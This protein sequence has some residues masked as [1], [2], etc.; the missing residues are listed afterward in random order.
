VLAVNRTERWWAAGQCV[1]ING[2]LAAAEAIFSAFTVVIT[3]CITICRWSDLAF[4]TACAVPDVAM[5][6]GWRHPLPPPRAASIFYIRA[7]VAFV[8][9]SWR[10]FRCRRANIQFLNMYLDHHTTR[11]NLYSS[12][13]ILCTWLCRSNSYSNTTEGCKTCLCYLTESGGAGQLVP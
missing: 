8:R 9:H 6:T 10:A 11:C 4:P 1:T 3:T 7:F 5:A 2:Q 12:R 13:A